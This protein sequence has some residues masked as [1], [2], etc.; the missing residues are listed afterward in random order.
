MDGAA[1]Q[2]ITP[3]N[4]PSRG[5]A[6]SPPRRVVRPNNAIGRARSFA[7]QPLSGQSGASPY[8]RSPFHLLEP[9]G[10]RFCVLAGIKRGDSEET[11]SLSAESCAG[12]DHYLDII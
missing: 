5:D 11:F 1:K 4:V 6:L 2:G 8:Q 9:L 3:L 10:N 7:L 12:G